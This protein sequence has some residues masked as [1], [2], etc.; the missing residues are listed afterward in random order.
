MKKNLS[1]QFKNMYLGNWTT[2]NHRN[3][4]D[5]KG[6]N[7]YK[8]PNNPKYFIEY[9]DKIVGLCEGCYQYYIQGNVILIEGTVLR[10]I[11]RGKGFTYP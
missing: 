10:G 1:E 6:S 7:G 5:V 8:C 11:R 2:E 4:C 9:K 3:K